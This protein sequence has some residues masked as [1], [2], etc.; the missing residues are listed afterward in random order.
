VL[1]LRATGAAL[2]LPGDVRTDVLLGD[3]RDVLP[4]T[5]DPA[6]TVIVTDPPYGLASTGGAGNGAPGVHGRGRAQTDARSGHETDKGYEDTIP[7]GQHVRD[8]LQLL[9]A[10]RHVI[11]GPAT[12]LIRRDHPQ[13]RR[14]CVEMAEYRRRAALRPGVVPYLWQGWAIYGRLKLERHARQ[15]QG[16]AL[17][18]RSLLQAHEGDLQMRRTSHRALTPYASALWMVET[19]VDPG[20]LVL[21]PFAGHGTIGRAARQFGFDYIGSE[22]VPEYHKVAVDGFAVERMMMDLGA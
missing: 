19:W 10:K 7:W 4:G 2:Q 13:P 3:W 15:P 17:T 20:D 16:D 8:V 1:R 22:I 9:P 12:M 14:V 6:R 5:Y 11:R 21:D 18:S